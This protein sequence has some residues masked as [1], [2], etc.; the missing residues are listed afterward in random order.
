MDKKDSNMEKIEVSVLMPIYNTAFYLR[1]AIDSVLNQT[2]NNFELILLNDCSTDA[3]AEIIDS[4]VDK[5]I[6]VYHAKQ[7]LGVA[8]IMNVGISIAR[9]KY[10]ARMDSDDI[11]LPNRL[12]YQVDYLDVH[13]EV[14]VCSCSMQQFGKSNRLM[15]YD[16]QIE[17]VKF[18]AMFFCPILN[19]ST[20]CRRKVFFDICF[21]QRFVPAEDYHFWVKVIC[22]GFN[23]VNLPI[24][25]Y[26]YRIFSEQATSNKRKVEIA[27]TMVRDEYIQ[28]MFPSI[29]Q[30]EQKLLLGIPS[31]NDMNVL[32]E[33]LDIWEKWNDKTLF[34]TPEFLKKK[35]KHYYQAR[36]Y[37]EMKENGII[38]S[39]LCSLRFK[40]IIKLFGCI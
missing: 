21:E 16:N 27:S 1:E 37:N 23:V 15:C 19:A 18:N 38:W 40:Q 5:R 4:Y 8:N 7:N 32:K 28:M 33:S 20:M 39:K 26:K 10:I 25:L 6:V 24:V 22:A 17:D 14:D 3:S 36:L 9:G 35:L 2:F 13:P 34:I 29:S 31:C 12:Q 11:S 30:Q